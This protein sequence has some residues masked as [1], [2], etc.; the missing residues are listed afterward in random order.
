MSVPATVSAQRSPSGGCKDAAAAAE[1]AADQGRL[2]E[3]VPRYRR[4]LSCQ[5]AWAE[6]WWR[7]GSILYELDRYAEAAVAFRT[8]TR[9]AP[10]NGD[11]FAMLGLCEARLGRRAA[12]LAHIA[13]GRQL[14]LRDEPRFMRVVWFTEGSLLLEEG[15]FAAAQERFEALAR[16]EVPAQQLAEPLARAVLGILPG[17]AAP[18]GL[19]D[20]A[21][22][23]QYFAAIRDMGNAKAYWKKVAEQFGA[24][25]NVHFAYGRY[26]LSI[27]ED[28][29]AVREFQAEIAA[30]PS[31]LLAHLG[32]AGAKAG[33]DPVFALPFAERAAQLAP[34]LGEARFLLG[35]ILLNLGDVRRA[36]IELERARRLSPREAKILF[37]LARAYS[38]AGRRADAERTQAL[39]QK[40]TEMNEKRTKAK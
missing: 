22:Q 28:D 29:L 9:L 15:R 37:Q 8:V 19:L 4:A 24:E 40:L 17:R 3:A 10:A 1:L 31:H 11:S 16:D 26:L 13:K 18:P 38:R 21:G 2:D 23:A 33:A 39:Y 35:M 27:Y 14:G 36:T 5:P 7:L 6:G 25:P 30:R 12:A 32:V 20:A 34:N